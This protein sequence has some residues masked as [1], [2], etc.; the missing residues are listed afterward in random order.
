MAWSAKE[1]A[2]LKENVGKMTPDEIGERIFKS[3]RAV[4]LYMYRNHIEPDYK[5]ANTCLVEKMLNIKFGN[6]KYFSPDRQWFEKA[7][8]GQK[9]FALLRRGKEQPTEDELKKIAKAI[10]MSTDELFELFKSR[11]LE[12]F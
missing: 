9:R 8:I 11:Q 6:A 10:Q 7:K 12:L 4:R 3:G 2:F 1:I 5:K